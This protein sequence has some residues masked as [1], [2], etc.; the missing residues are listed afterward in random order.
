MYD[1]AFII[2]IGTIIFIV[3]AFFITFFLYSYRQRINSHYQEKQE[4]KN[5]Y[6]QEI[7]KAQLEMQ[8]QTFRTISQEIHDN[9][10]Q[11]LS[12]A[13]LNISTIITENDSA[14]EQKKITSK[15]LLDK[16]IEDLRD[17]SKRLDADFISQQSLAQSL[18][19]QLNLIQ[20]TELYGTSLEVQ[21][22]ERPLH[23][24]KKLIIFRIAQEALNNIIKHAEAKTI[25]VMLVFMPDKIVLNIKDDGLGFNPKEATKSLGLHNMEQ[26]AKLIGARFSVQSIPSEGTSAQLILPKENF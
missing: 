8:E 20:K 4:L 14:S 15:N 13:R 17:L 7:L 26:R 3:I 18:K 10:G 2:S 19:F 25:S 23:S 9:I 12:L 1:I 16:A 11:I 24:E 5:I 6:Q 21:G 22:K